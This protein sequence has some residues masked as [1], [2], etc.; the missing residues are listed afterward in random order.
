MSIV[1]GV[2]MT[3]LLPLAANAQDWQNQNAQNWQ[4]TSVMQ[5][6]GSSYSSQVTAVGAVSASHLGTTTTETYSP[7]AGGPRRVIGTNPDPGITDD[8]SSPIGDAMLP[9]LLMA[10]VFCGAIYFRRKRAAQKS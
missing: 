7:Q 6:S 3:C 1:A 9:L 8:N 2:L 10:V 5:G 4:T